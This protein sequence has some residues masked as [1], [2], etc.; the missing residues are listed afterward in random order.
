MS[1]FAILFSNSLKKE[2]KMIWNLLKWLV[3]ELPHYKVESR[4]EDIGQWHLK[5]AMETYDHIC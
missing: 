5:R 1:I 2:V 3:A 4:V